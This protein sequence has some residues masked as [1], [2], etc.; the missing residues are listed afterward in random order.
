MSENIVNEVKEEAVSRYFP[1]TKKDTFFAFLIAAATIV[2]TVLGL[3]GGFRIGYTVS[4]VLLF[5]VVTAYLWGNKTKITFFSLLCGILALAS[6]AIFFITSNGSVRF[7]G[8][9]AN[10]L[11]SAVW[12]GSLVNFGEFSGDLE[13]V[14][15]LFTQIFSEMFGK[16]PKS[17]ATL[18]SVKSDRKTGFGKVLLGIVLAIPVLFVII[19]LLISSDAAFAGFVLKFFENL[20]ATFFKA[21][22]GLFIAP[23]M[24]SYCFALKFSQRREAR[25]G[26]FNGIDN[27][28]VVS[29][30]SVISV[31][32]LAYLFSQLAYFFSAFSG[33]LPEGYKFNL[34]TYARRGF[35]EMSVIA[36]INFVIIFL[37]LLL[38]R[39]KDEKIFMSSRL[40]CLF[41]SVF[42]LMII[43]TALSK[44]V[45][46]IRELGM[47]RLRITT[48]AFMLF[49]A[50][51]FISVILR[52]FIKKVKVLRVALV[53]AGC[54][55]IAL[56][57]FNVNHVVAAYN[58]EAYKQGVLKE[59]DVEAIYKLGD[60]G[61]PYLLKLTEDD[62]ATVSGRAHNYIDK[63][64]WKK[65]YETELDYNKHVI[66][67]KRYNSLEDYSISR[68]KAYEVLDE[69]ISEHPGLYVIPE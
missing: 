4:S 45:L 58:Y 33:F 46:Y 25:P 7:W 16:L 2:F 60:E 49:L 68:A 1:I 66:N 52:L 36:A 57:T 26:G 18:F 65:Y 63:M 34:S 48:S 62:D 9:V 67:T 14:K 55:L 13:L 24:V 20:S 5:A 42:T 44:M 8:F 31:C 12:F 11:L 56:G 38:S 29:F 41:I 22:F 27:T 50:I 10:L 64:I 28:I 21:I 39:K 35:F 59:M 47:T 32:Y 37:T 53:T 15:N 19:P 40:V 6:P 61:V 23:F 3:F 17:I 43:A 69:Y 54:V 51:V 30:L